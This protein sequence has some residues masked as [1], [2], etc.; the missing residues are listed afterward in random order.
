[1]ARQRDRGADACALGILGI[2]EIQERAY[3]LLLA[4][5]G[6]TRPE[7]ARILALP[8]AVTQQ[9]LETLEVRGLA[10]HSPDQPQRYFP[11]PPDMGMEALLIERQRELQRARTAI[12]AFKEQVSDSRRVDQQPMVELL[13]AGMAERQVLEQLHNTAQQEILR[14]VR[15]PI[16]LSD[17]ADSHD[18]QREA[19]A[20]GV[21]YRNI[22]DAES[23]AL[24]LIA[25]AVLAD[26]GS[27]QE[28]RALPLP[29][30]KFLIADRRIALMLLLPGQSG[31]RV[32]LVRQSALLEALCTLFDLLWERATPLLAGASNHFEMIDSTLGVLAE[33][34]QLVTMMAA[35]MNDKAIAHELGLSIRTLNRRINLLMQGLEVRT[36][37]QAGWLARE[38]MFD[39]RPKS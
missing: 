35:G 32:L 24:P 1:M 31:G 27:G 30:F 19:Q 15:G 20:R 39:V 10:S 3:R 37:F 9:V 5:P 25:S 33:V 26:I 22:V 29:P 8:A 14:L 12:E 36:R 4:Q 34:E 16:Q 13:A 28:Y 17:L 6:A 38:R 2:S 18:P 7:V 21:R 23:M 11:V